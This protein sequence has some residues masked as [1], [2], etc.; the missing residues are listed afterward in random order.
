[1]V[2]MTQVKFEERVAEA[3]RDLFQNTTSSSTTNRAN[4]ATPTRSQRGSLSEEAI[5]ARQTSAA[6]STHGLTS[7]PTLVAVLEYKR[8]KLDLV[9]TTTSE[10]EQIKQNQISTTT[11]GSNKRFKALDNMLHVIGLY[12]M[13]AGTRREP[14]PTRQ[15]PLGYSEPTTSE[16]LDGTYNY[17]LADDVTRWSHDKKRLYN[18]MLVAFH[19]YTHYLCSELFLQRDRITIYKKMHKHYYGHTEADINRLRRL[20]QNFKG[21]TATYFKE[22]FVKFLALLLDFEYAQARASTEQERLQLLHQ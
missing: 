3:A 15:N 17:I 19:E 21:S 10:I 4:V 9:L 2:T 14:I 13:A 18:V 8:L 16:N 20:L 1:M 11:V 22:D 7:N 6:P 5:P 12:P